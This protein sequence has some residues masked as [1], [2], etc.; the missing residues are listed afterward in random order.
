MMLATTSAAAESA[1]GLLCVR[2][3]RYFLSA[4]TQLAS[5][6]PGHPG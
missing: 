4:A 1:P 6:L 3:P 5:A 2:S